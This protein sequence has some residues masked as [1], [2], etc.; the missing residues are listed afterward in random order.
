MTEREARNLPLL[1]YILTRCDRPQC[2]LHRKQYTSLLCHIYHVIVTQAVQIGLRDLYILMP[3]EAR[4]GIKVSS[5]FYLLLGEKMAARM[6][7]NANPRYPLAVLLQD[8]L[9][10]GVR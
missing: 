5:H 9:H 10:G 3:Q 8:V 2:I 6:R 1:F 4:Y 7:R